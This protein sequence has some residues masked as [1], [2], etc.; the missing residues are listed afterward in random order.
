M[1]SLNALLYRLTSCKKPPTSMR[2]TSE[3]YSRNWR[4]ENN[5]YKGKCLIRDAWKHACRA[6]SPTQSWSGRRSVWVSIVLPFTNH[7]FILWKKCCCLNGRFLDF[8]V[9]IASLFVCAGETGKR[10]A[11]GDAKQ[12]LGKGWETEAA[13]SH[14]D[15]WE[16]GEQTTTAALQRKGQSAP[17]EIRIPVAGSRT[18]NWN[19]FL[20]RLNWLTLCLTYYTSL[21]LCMVCCAVRVNAWRT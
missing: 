5:G 12:T 6:S 17:Q 13:Q 21:R 9:H 14:R 1:K 4:A 11:A 10:Q 2:R 19:A 3:V 7:T 20:D 16:I 15:R 18:F 8:V